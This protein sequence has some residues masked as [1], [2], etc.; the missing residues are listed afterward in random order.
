MRSQRLILVAVSIFT[1]MSVHT[2]CG[3]TIEER[4][5]AND[6]EKVLTT[7]LRKSGNDISKKLA[8]NSDAVKKLLKWHQ[9]T[10]YVLPW[11]R[12]VPSSN[13]STK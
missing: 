7:C 3:A 5:Y 8:C 4:A 2:T 12:N 9:G 11:H 13:N 1:F 10:F 6:V